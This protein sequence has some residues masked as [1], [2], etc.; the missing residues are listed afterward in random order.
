MNLKDLKIAINDPLTSDEH[1]EYIIGRIL[2]ADK[3]AIPMIMKVLETERSNN[4]ELITEMNHELSR[5][6]VFIDDYM[7]EPV[8]LKKG[9]TEPSFNKKFITDKIAEFYIQYKGIIRH[10]Y[11]RFN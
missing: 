7:P 3:D 8:K 9:Q 6:H 4:K 2:A 10:C 11:N 1:K 5:A